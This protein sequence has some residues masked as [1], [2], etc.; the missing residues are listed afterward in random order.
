VTAWMMGDWR[1]RVRRYYDPSEF[2]GE[3]SQDDL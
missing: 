1:K 2:A 3:W